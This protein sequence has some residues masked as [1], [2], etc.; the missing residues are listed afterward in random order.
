MAASAVIMV[1]L[2]VRER[3]RCRIKVL[4]PSIIGEMFGWLFISAAA[5]VIVLSSWAIPPS[6]I[7]ETHNP[8]SFWSWI[9]VWIGLCIS[10]LFRYLDLRLHYRSHR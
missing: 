10:S 7:V 9:L 8:L 3:K 4:I 1:S 6:A 2:L 5:A